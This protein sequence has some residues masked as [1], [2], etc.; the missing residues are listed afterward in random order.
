VLTPALQKLV[1]SVSKILNTPLSL[2]G[3]G[4]FSAT[5]SAVQPFACV[6][7]LSGSRTG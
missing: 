7:I 6:A 2:L 1:D 4:Q 3:A 5:S